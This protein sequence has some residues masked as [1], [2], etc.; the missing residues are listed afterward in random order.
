MKTGEKGRRRE[1]SRTL[2]ADVRLNMGLDV[3]FHVEL[4]TELNPRTL[5]S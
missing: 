1:F 3:V 4:D 2:H 5:E